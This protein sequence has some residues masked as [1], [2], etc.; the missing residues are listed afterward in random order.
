[1]PV[2]EIEMEI[3]LG[4]PTATIVAAGTFRLGGLMVAAILIVTTAAAVPPVFEAVMVAANTPATVGVP[5]IT[6]ESGSSVNP[7]GRLLALKVKGAFEAVIEYGVEKD[8]TA[9]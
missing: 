5:E 6:P 4:S 9:A 3:E 2:V 8:P 1:M 7:G